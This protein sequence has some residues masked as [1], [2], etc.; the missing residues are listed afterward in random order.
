MKAAGKGDVPTKRPVVLQVGVNTVTTLVENKKAQLVVT[1]HDVDPIEL[2]VF[3]PMS[4]DGG[5]LLHYQ[6][7]GQVGMPG[8]Q[9]NMYHCRLHTGNS[10]D[11]GALAKLVEAIRTN[12]NDRY[13][14]IHR[15]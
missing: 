10:E 2:F 13:N 3:L 14:E 11:N 8:P 6:R 4:E 5:S 7:E 1:A 12:Y 15:H 9:E